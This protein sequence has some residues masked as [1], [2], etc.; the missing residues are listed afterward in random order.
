MNA[1]ARTSQQR[2]RNHALQVIDKI[3]DVYSTDDFLEKL[4][5]HSLP[6]ECP[7]QVRQQQSW[8]PRSNV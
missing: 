6:S 8:C 4:Q 1:A 2:C 3:N 7:P 5:H